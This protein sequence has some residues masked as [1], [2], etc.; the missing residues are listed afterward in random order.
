MDFLA[1]HQISGVVFLTGDRH[2]SEVIELK[3]PNGLY[4]LYDIT[5][6]PLTSGI[7]KARGVEENNPYRVPNTLVEL[8]NFSKIS[9]TGKKKERELQVFFLGNKGDKLAEWKVSEAD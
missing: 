4:P 9:V 2:H 6:S 7:A 5:S 8:Q 3:R 1:E